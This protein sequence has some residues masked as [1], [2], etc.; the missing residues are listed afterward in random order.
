MG[1]GVPG[2][3]ATIAGLCITGSAFLADEFEMKAA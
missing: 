2:A 3:P 1:G